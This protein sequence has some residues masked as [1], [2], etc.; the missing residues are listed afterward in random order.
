MD[1]TE[2]ELNNLNTLENAADW[3]GTTG[4]VHDHL[5]GKLG[6][7]SKLRDLVFIARPAWDT[8]VASLTI[9]EPQADGTEAERDLTPVEFSR[10]EI[11]RRV[12]FL[13][14]K[15]NPDGPGG[16]GPP[17]PIVG[18]APFPGTGGGQGPSSPTRKLK[19]S[20]IVDPTLD[21][22]ILQLGQEEIAEMFSKYKSKFGDVPS[23]DV[24]PSADQISAI[25]QL[26]TSGA[27]PYIDMSIFG[28][29]A[30]RSLRR[31]VFSSYTLNAATGEWSKKE[32][33]GPATL[34]Q[35]EKS[36]KTYK[37]AMLLLE[38]A[39]AERLEGYLEHIKDLH[40]QFGQEAWGII[41]R[42]DVRMRSEFQERI[43]RALDEDPKYGYT[44]ASPWSSVFAA[45]V[46]ESDFWSK[47]VATPATLLLARNKQLA[48]EESSSQEGRPQKRKSRQPEGTQKKKAKRKYTGEDRSRW[49][50]EQ[51]RY[52]LNRKGIQICQKY[53]RGACG[54]GKP[55][56][57]CENNRSHQCDKSPGGTHRP[58]VKRPR[59]EAAPK[60][61]SPENE[62]ASHHK[63]PRQDRD[64]K[65][66]NPRE[67][68]E[69]GSSSDS[70]SSS[71]SSSTTVQAGREKIPSMPLYVDY[72]YGATNL[73]PQ[74]W[75][76]RP[77]ALLL[78]SGRPRD[79]D[80]TSYLHHMG[81][82]VVVVDK[83]GPTAADLL[84]TE[85]CRK[86][87]AD[88]RAGV[89]DVVG[90][91]TPCETV[92]PLRE[93]P[94]G[95]RPLRSLQ[96]P[97]GL[98]LKS[99][100]SEE[101]KQLKEANHLIEFSTHV[102]REVRRIRAAYWIENPDHKEKLDMWKT[103]WFKE[104]T[105]H[106]LVEKALFDQCQFGAETTKPTRIQ[107][108]SL[109]L[110]QIKG[111]RCNHPP[112]EWTRPN[113]ETY[114]S[115]HESLV[116]RW[117]TVRGEKERASKALGE[118]TPA[119]N[120]ALAEAMEKADLPRVMKHREGSGAPLGF[121]EPIPRT[122]IFPVVK[123][124]EWEAEDALEI[125]RK[126]G[127]PAFLAVDIRDAFHNIPSG[128]DRAFTSAAFRDK[129][130]TLKI[131]VYDV[132]VFGSVS[133]PTLRGRYAAWFG[134]RPVIGRR[135]L[136][137]L[138]GALSFVAG[139]V[140]LMRPFL[141]S[142]WAALATN[143]GPK[144]TRN[145][146]HVRRIGIALQWIDALL[147][148]KAGPVYGTV[149]PGHPE[150]AAP[151]AQPGVKAYARGSLNDAIRHAS[152]GPERCAEHIT[153]RAKADTSRGPYESRKSTW[154]AL[155]R[156]AGFSD[157]FRLSPDLINT[158]MGAM[159][160]AGYRSA[161]LYM[162]TAK[163]IHIERGLDWTAQLAQASGQARRACQRGRGPAKQAQPLPMIELAKLKVHK[164]PAA[165]GGPIFP[166]RSVMLA[167]WWLLREIEASS[168]ERSHIEI[169]KVQRLIHWKLPS[170]KADWQALGATRTH[171]CNCEQNARQPECPYHAMVEH[172]EAVGAIS[173]RWVFPSATGEQSSKCGWADTMQ[174]MA[175]Q[176]NLPTHTD[177]GARRFTG[178]SARATSAV[179][180]A[181][182]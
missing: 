107:T 180:L 139:L 112:R 179:Y 99:L 26:L 23:A 11:F 176:L 2:E 78:F 60:R 143:D 20:S 100:S 165:P 79:G 117:R 129:T 140:P 55:Q 144:Q 164:D 27:L 150:A 67:E 111:R 136:Q 170:S 57:R 167:S 160:M 56:S 50:A 62:A 77:R 121:T 18:A 36:F 82:I 103:S 105:G 162:D 114:V 118:Y 113:G 14:L 47:E 92:S 87:F 174:C 148:E 128:K 95:P 1:P 115:P 90:M 120:K 138:A 37:V 32:S 76:D 59:L 15:V 178:H 132:L 41:Y 45:T 46:R 84:D 44:R 131:V 85:V 156:A 74:L 93:N 10:V 168:A 181:Q 116:Q 135:Q 151:L 149:D 71:T 182:T 97:D 30:I 98:P 69:P 158:V 146:V 152:T 19:L 29:H 38:A 22:E 130:G 134:R 66:P 173:D 123:E 4:A 39:D 61:A 124:V 163:Q 104:M 63:R 58:A 96:H 159:D 5:M 101:R 24:E 73:D 127:K 89:F 75:D 110:G 51:S 126:G 154:S 48:P 108:D 6:K 166:M 86:I 161:E 16:A 33:P 53:N 54:N 106:A 3:A 137:S 157:P 70:S 31:S 153:K 21:A 83:Q 17:Q 25:K 80:L 43:R 13:R 7:P 155:A 64:R 34:Q 147:G 42:A 175:Q 49:D 52:S 81:W 35:W 88:I 109:P 122:G 65:A 94:P 68:E 102:T 125:F 9:K 72:K 171:S 119:L 172:L 28:P 141:N 145:V 91:A 12:V 177:T 169:D 142:L 40:A 133:S 8:V